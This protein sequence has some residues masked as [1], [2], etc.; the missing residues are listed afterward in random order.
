MIVSNEQELH[1]DVGEYMNKSDKTNDDSQ[2]FVNSFT[3]SLVTLT[4][5][6]LI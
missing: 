1:K 3:T 2:G 6:S 5:F 4:R